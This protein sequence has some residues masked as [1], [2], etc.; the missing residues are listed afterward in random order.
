M[1]T[2]MLA[3]PQVNYDIL[4]NGGP[5]EEWK[6]NVALVKDQIS[7]EKQLLSSDSPTQTEKELCIGTNQRVLRDSEHYVKEGPTS[8]HFLQITKTRLA[9]V[10]ALNIHPEAAD[11][12]YDNYFTAFSSWRS[13]DLKTPSGITRF[14]EETTKVGFPKE[15]LDKRVLTHIGKGVVTSKD[16]RNDILDKRAAADR[17]QDAEARLPSHI[18][19]KEIAQAMNITEAELNEKA[20]DLIAGAC[21]VKN[22]ISKNM[23]LRHDLG[24]HPVLEVK[25]VDIDTV[26]RAGVRLGIPEQKVLNTM[27]EIWP[28]PTIDDLKKVQ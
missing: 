25:S 15:Q 28:T 26:V 5:D 22:D 12:V 14:F 2:E 19:T 11:I 9:L 23:K 18:L 17:D 27:K 20:F 7:K 21:N 24:M 10:D 3:K 6:K 1:E 13:D 4:F 8:E 16:T